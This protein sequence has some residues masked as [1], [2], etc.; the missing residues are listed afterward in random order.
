MPEATSHTFTLDIEYED[1]KKEQR[2]LVTSQA[3]SEEY[4]VDHWLQ[5][6]PHDRIKHIH[7][8]AGAVTVPDHIKDQIKNMVPKTSEQLLDEKNNRKVTIS[9]SSK[10][11]VAEMTSEAIIPEKE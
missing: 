5:T 4:A 2:S 9:T 6:H 11:R 1:G 8:D 3:V 10:P 7:V